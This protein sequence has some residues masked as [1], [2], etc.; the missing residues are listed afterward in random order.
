MEQPNRAAL[1]PEQEKDALKRMEENVKAQQEAAVVQFKM[2]ARF[3]AISQ[4]PTRK[5][6]AEEKMPKEL[7]AIEKISEAEII[8]QWLIKEL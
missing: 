6:V 4:T 7:T 5:Y 1:T 8:Y 2:K 3:E